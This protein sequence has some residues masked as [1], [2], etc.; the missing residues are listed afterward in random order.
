MIKIG[1]SHEVSFV[2]PK[3]TINQDGQMVTYEGDSGK[4]SGKDSAVPWALLILF[5]SRAVRDI[6]GTEQQ[7][8]RLLG[9]TFT[10]CQGIP[11]PPD[12]K[13]PWEQ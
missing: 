10:P 7:R 13:A 4:M 11:L 6:D 5:R 9:F 8:L 2:S 3:G 1:N 12:K